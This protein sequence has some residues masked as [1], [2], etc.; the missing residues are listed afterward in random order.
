[1]RR[2]T[3]GLLAGILTIYVV[4]GILYAARTPDWQIPDE[5]AHYNY[6]RQIVDD[7]RIP[8]IQPGDW[9]SAY[10]NQLVGSGFDPQY[11][12]EIA[13]VQYED[14]QPPLYYLLAAPIYAISDGD[15]L[16]LR[17]FSVV[18]GFGVVLCAFLVVMRL[19]P[20]R[21]WL[22]LTTA[23]FVAFIPQHLM[24]LGGVNNDPLAELVVAGTL[25][26]VV[27]Y[28]Q[29]DETRL[30]DVAL[31][32][33]LVGLGFLTKATI[34][35]MA[36]VAGVAILIK[37]RRTHWPLTI[38]ARHI[39]A[40]LMPALLLGAIWWIHN[41]DVYG[42]TDFLGLQRHD[43]VAA[44]QLQTEDYIERDLNGDVGQYRRNYLYTTFHSFWGQFGWMALPMPTRIYRVLLLTTLAAVAGVG[45]AFGREG[46]PRSLNHP[47]RESLLLM[48]LM[49]LLVLAAYIVYNLTFVQFQGR[50][51][52]PALIPVG[53]FFA[54]GLAG[55]AGLPAMLGE[56]YAILKWASVIAILLLAFL[57]WY[58][59]DTYIVPAFPNRG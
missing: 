21:P 2:I 1:M 11:T 13:R 46:W 10:Q 22:A 49:A 41:L 20:E 40:F 19:F 26:A 23:G 50:Y 37:W 29:S 53:L 48:G 7:G 33:V 8:V 32:G 5:P 15:L 12:G 9:D 58:A 24:M 6:I 56:R 4:L 25:L 47:Q 39:A 28:L 31:M 57:A 54:I 52:Y 18:L 59:L 51:L 14:H 17:L 43:E 36:G 30:R 34:Y 27:H 55:L 45:V 3:F 44:G 42:G 16:T 35:F 38:A